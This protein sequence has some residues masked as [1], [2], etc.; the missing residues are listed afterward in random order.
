MNRRGCRV[1]W[2]DEAILLTVAKAAKR[3]LLIE[4]LTL[5]HG[6]CR[7][8][9]RMGDQEAPLLLPGSFLDIGYTAGAPGQLGEG[10]L[11]DVSGGVV[12]ETQSSVSLSVVAA[13]KDMTCLF[14]A[15]GQPMPRVFAPAQEL[16]ESL[17]VEDQRW[18]LHYGFWEF[19]LFEAMGHI[20]GVRRCLPAQRLGEAIYLSRRTGKVVTREEAGAFLDRMVPL[21]GF[22][23]GQK[24]ATIVDARLGFDLNTLIAEQ[25]ALAGKGG[26]TLPPSRAVVAKAL[27]KIQQ[28]PPIPANGPLPI[29]EEARRKR[30]LALKPLMVASRP[31]GG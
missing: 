3:V 19:T 25:F 29:D 2:R 1:E 20:D 4:S 10:R 31:G 27:Q 11:L 22:L 14:I 8:L 18:P 30:I 12:A 26:G 15:E 7:M 6:R 28:I 17:S 24:T 16:L 23:M 13:F 5:S 9:V 21:P